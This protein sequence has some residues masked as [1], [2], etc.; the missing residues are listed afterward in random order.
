MRMPGPITILEYQP[1]GFR[2]G[3]KKY[4]TDTRLGWRL[5]HE[6]D[7]DGFSTVNLLQLR[8]LEI[9][10]LMDAIVGMWKVDYNCIRKRLKLGRA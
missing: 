4:C 2:W 3:M 8:K 10:K 9:A 1:D 7:V 6:N 5:C